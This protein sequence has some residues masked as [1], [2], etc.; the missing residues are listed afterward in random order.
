VGL[1]F[2][3][4]A[5][6]QNEGKP[7]VENEPEIAE[8][9]DQSFTV[10]DAKKTPR[11]TH[12]WDF[13][14]E[15]YRLL[16]EDLHALLDMDGY[17]LREKLLAQSVYMDILIDSKRS[18]LQGLGSANDGE[19]MGRLRKNFIEQPERLFG[20]AG[21]LRGSKQLHRA[22]LG[23]IVAFRQSLYDR[24]V[25]PKRLPTILKIVRH[26]AVHASRLGKID[27]EFVDTP[28]SYRNFREITYPLES[29]PAMKEL[30]YRYLH[31]ALHRKDLL[32]S[33]S[34]FMGQRFL[35]THV[36][37]IY[38]HAVAVASERGKTVCDVDD[39]RESLNIVERMYSHHTS[40][41]ELFQKFPALGMIL[42]GIVVKKTFAPSLTGS[43]V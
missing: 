38:W 29:D 41:G 22:F 40:F 2:A 35:L 5:V 23:L 10:R 20:L 18:V 8:Y 30:I 6:L 36:A 33:E 16:E 27:L 42:D 14:W 19:L 11:L 4:T 9:Y 28:I 1:S 24:D 3:C 17:T 39:L 15:G 13:S 32:V 12:Q 21:K 37:L 25:R 7:L 43:A 26:F 31:H 34:I